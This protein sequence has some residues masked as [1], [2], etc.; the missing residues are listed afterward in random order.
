MSTSKFT[1]T[2][3]DVVLLL[4]LD[5]HTP[6]PA[7]SGATNPEWVPVERAAAVVGAPL[8]PLIDWLHHRG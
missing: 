2:P 7:T 6:R 5:Q 8:G 3:T 1:F 4:A